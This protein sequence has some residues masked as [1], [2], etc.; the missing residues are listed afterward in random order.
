[1][2]KRN[3]ALRI[4]LLSHFKSLPVPTFSQILHRIQSLILVSHTRPI[5]KA[6]KPHRASHPYL[7]PSQGQRPRFRSHASAG[8]CFN[9]TGPHRILDSLKDIDVRRAAENRLGF[10]RKKRSA[11]PGG[12][13]PQQAIHF[14]QDCVYEFVDVFDDLQS[15]DKLRTLPRMGLLLGRIPGTLFPLPRPPTVPLSLGS[16][17]EVRKLANANLHPLLYASIIVAKSSAKPT[18]RCILRL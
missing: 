1:M 11:A 7:S 2:R 18:Q 9:C 14:L 5:C 6:A 15:V 3:N 17:P 10:F 16:L 4:F 12:V 13:P 8:P